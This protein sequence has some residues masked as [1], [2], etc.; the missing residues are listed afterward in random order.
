MA[1][2]GFFVFYCISR[3]IVFFILKILFNIEVSGRGNIPKDGP[4]L[5]ASNH[6]SYL[7]PLCVGVACRR[8]LNFMARHDLFK[9][10]LFSKML[11]LY[12]VFPVKRD[13]ADIASIRKA[14]QLLRSG[15][16]LVIFPE[17][18]RQKFAGS[19][20]ETKSGIG[21]LAVKSTA[22]VV[23]VLVKGTDKILPR[24]AHFIR[25][26]KIRVYFGRPVI[27]GEG[28]SYDSVS[29]E[30]MEKINALSK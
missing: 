12:G 13:S 14:V 8:R 29:R 23:P 15:K 21:F 3:A 20:A 9:N 2:Q 16:A 4:V 27:F 25:P 5:L 22:Q 10:P 26:G 17:G 1:Y 28:L 24:G 18:R 6:I 19:E 30:I 11:N 7:D